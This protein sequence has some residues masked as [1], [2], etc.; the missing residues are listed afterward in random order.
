MRLS[1][2]LYVAIVIALIAARPASAS[3]VSLA[4]PGD[5]SGYETLIT[6]DDLGIPSNDEITSGKG[7]MFSLLGEGTLVDL[8]FSPTSAAAPNST[9]AR[10]FPPRD[11]RFFLNNL[12]FSS[13]LAVPPFRT[14]LMV[15][16]PRGVRRAAAEIRSGNTPNAAQY[17]DLH[18]ELYDDVDLV[19]AV[20]V[21]IRGLD[22]FFFYGLESDRL[23]DRWVIRQRS[24]TSFSL[25]NLR[26][27]V[28]E[29]TTLLLL[30]VGLGAA[31][32]APIRGS[33]ASGNR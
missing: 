25:E 11:G 33:G 7:V 22:D 18:F 1:G 8:G 13:P 24:L 31:G 15:T 14:D 26:F 29:P 12:N 16:F 19:G 2:L 23:F 10:E 3:I 21:P 20:T 4:S 28:P 30:A 27:E 6:F 32:V 9:Y 5:F 17:Q